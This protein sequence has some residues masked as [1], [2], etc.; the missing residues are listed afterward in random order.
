MVK[1]CPIPEFKDTLFLFFIWAVKICHHSKVIIH[2]DFCCAAAILAILC[3]AHAPEA[4][5][6]GARSLEVAALVAV[7]HV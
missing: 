1:L 7:F 6:V 2:C 4:A 3:R 5:K